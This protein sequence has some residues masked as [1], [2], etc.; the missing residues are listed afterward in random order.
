MRA[1]K[2]WI[3]CI[4]KEHAAFAFKGG[5][6][7]ACHGKEWP[8]R[9]MQKDDEI[10]IYSSKEEMGDT[11]SVLQAF[12][13]IGRVADNEIYQYAMSEDFIPF[14]R[15]VEYYECEEASILPLISSLRFIPNKK[16]WGYPFRYGIVEIGVKDFE[17]ICGEMRCKRERFD[18]S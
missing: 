12:T 5:I 9:Q 14:R 18:I 6:I 7:Q 8:L 13:A 1:K 10:V 3:V 17:L 4:S 16:F 15:K 11:K 2:Y